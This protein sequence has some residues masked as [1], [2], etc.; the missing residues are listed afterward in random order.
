MINVAIG[1]AAIEFEGREYILRPSFYSMQRIGSPEEIKD[2]AEWCLSASQRIA[3]G[4][5]LI[6]DELYACLHV[7]QSCCDLDIPHELFGY[8][9][10]DEINEKEWL[11]VEGAA[12]VENLVILAN[13]MLN[14]GMNGKPSA[15]MMRR[16]KTNKAKPSLFDPLEFV[17][18]AVCHLGLSFDDAWKLTMIQLQRAIE[19]KFPEDKKK[20]DSMMTAAELLALKAKIKGR[21]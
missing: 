8:Y 14:N 3:A 12:P 15:F 18:S 5:M 1:D 2:T 9:D 11:F 16:A 13:L 7:L 10:V 19:N 4:Q 6:R 17:S 21:K 20:A